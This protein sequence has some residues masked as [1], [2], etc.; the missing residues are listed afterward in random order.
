ML[1]GTSLSGPDGLLAC[2]PLSGGPKKGDRTGALGV[3]ADALKLYPE[4]ESVS[5]YLIFQISS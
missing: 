4:G 5:I 2:I 3:F 1:G